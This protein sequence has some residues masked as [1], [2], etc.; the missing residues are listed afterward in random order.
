M[1]ITTALTDQELKLFR[2]KYIAFGYVMKAKS[3]PRKEEIANM[4]LEDWGQGDVFKAVVNQLGLVSKEVDGCIVYQKNPLKELEKPG[5]L[6]HYK[7]ASSKPSF[8]RN[9]DLRNKS[10]DDLLRE[11][12]LCH[13]VYG[14]DG[15]H[16]P[17]R[18]EDV[19]WMLCYRIASVMQED[20]CDLIA[21]V[22]LA[23][24]YQHKVHPTARLE[25]KD[26]GWKMCERV[27]EIIYGFS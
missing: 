5:S 3:L 7:C 22:A 4:A 24:A 19:L 1:T 20:H 26:A 13:E 16:D 23:I 12:K 10:M 25:W 15:E 9:P 18:I 17:D 14:V 11:L 27:L 2:D 8:E 6:E 21:A